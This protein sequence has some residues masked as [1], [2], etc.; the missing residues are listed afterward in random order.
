[1]L[2]HTGNDILEIF[3]A[4]VN[5]ISVYSDDISLFKFAHDSDLNPILLNPWVCFFLDS[6]TY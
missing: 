2:R 5:L 6:N 3:F 1:M 4:N